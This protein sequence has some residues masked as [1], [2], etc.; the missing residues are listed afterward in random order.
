MSDF[1]LRAVL[2]FANRSRAGTQEARQDL[3]RLGKSAEGVS[4]AFDQTSSTANRL[5]LV[6]L[7]LADAKAK[8]TRE[9]DDLKRAQLQV[10]TDDLTQQQQ[11]LNQE[12]Q[13]G[14]EQVS[15]FSKAATVL[16]GVLGSLAA[17]EIIKTAYELARL[18]TQSRAAEERLTALSGSTQEAGRYLRDMRQ[19]T[20]YTMSS[21]DGMALANKFLSMGLAE[22]SDEAAEFAMMAVR[23]GDGM[24]SAEQR[25]AKFSQLLQN[26][27]IRLLDD[28]GISSGATTQRIAELQEEISGL[29]REDAFRMA[30]LEQGRE[31]IERLGDAGL[32]AA[33]SFDRLS[34]A[35]TD[36]KAR[37]GDSWLGDLFA[38]AAEG[39]ALLLSYDTRL[40]DMLSSHADQAIES[41]MAWEEYAQ[42][43]Y[44][45]L[46]VAG[47]FDTWELSVRIAEA[48]GRAINEVTTEYNDY[49]LLKE[50]AI[51]L[52]IG[53]EEVMSRNVYEA[54]QLADAANV[55]GYG[56]SY[57]G[58]E[59][60]KGLE[61][62]EGAI[63]GVSEGALAN[64]RDSMTQLMGKSDEATGKIVLGFIQ[65]AAAADGVITEEELEVMGALAEK[66]G[67]V[68]DAAVTAMAQAR[69]GVDNLNS[70]LLTTEETINRLDG[71]MRNLPTEHSMRIHLDVDGSVPG[72]SVPGSVDIG[73]RAPLPGTGTAPA[74]QQPS[75]VPNQAPI[76]Q[77]EGGDWMVTRPTLF[78]AGEAGPERATFRPVAP[79]GEP[80]GGGG[81]T[82]I[83]QIFTSAPVDTPQLAA[84][85]DTLKTLRGA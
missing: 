47:R 4:G 39:A 58:A 76:P 8:L 77:A 31:A 54:H 71:A 26:Q 74:R 61:E 35:W 69:A 37:A 22:S 67:L 2:E 42:A 13:G 85:F 83:L 41:G 40:S 23:L 56:W 25:T 80:A 48:E 78:L 6:S 72:W 49:N 9:T 18:G 66:W 19:A 32:G 7:Q 17:R 60:T 1:N 62:V 70:G 50:R 20:D 81:D 38:N 43:Q 15:G 65:Q 21:L 36:F 30:V 28:F 11:R 82:Y 24:L 79:A 64:Y 53:H 57:A 51:E 44:D 27:S 52:G 12:L 33:S 29:T 75:P 5:K 3:E 84:G 73:N 46:E 16:Q 68:D 10:R 45:A 34:A 14:T 59:I 55:V 63:R